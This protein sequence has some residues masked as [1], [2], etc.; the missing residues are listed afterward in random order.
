AER[1][2][3]LGS[4]EAALARLLAGRLALDLGRG[5]EA[6]RHFV[7]AARGRRHG[8]AMSRVSAWL[9][10]ALRAD[11]AGESQ[12]MLAACRQGRRVLDEHRF[13][14]GASELRALATAHGA[15]LAKLAQRHALRANRPRLLFDW[16]ERW[17][18]TTLTVPVVRPTADPQLNA[19]LAALRSVTK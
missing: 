3:D 2:E 5:T 10:E 18:A 4:P 15:E 6:E 13:P 19:G 16:T 12:R 9:G 1:L 17:R 8:L 7:A 11:A 14:M